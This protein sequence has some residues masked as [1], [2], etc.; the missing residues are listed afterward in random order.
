MKKKSTD[1]NHNSKPS[2]SDEHS[3]EQAADK[4][5]LEEQHILLDL[6]HIR[7]RQYDHA[8]NRLAVFNK[9]EAA[10]KSEKPLAQITVL[11]PDGITSMAVTNAQELKD[12]L[13]AVYSD[14]HGDFGLDEM[15]QEASARAG[16]KLTD[17]QLQY[18]RKVEEQP[19]I[20]LPAQSM[21]EMHAVLKEK[22][23]YHHFGDVLQEEEDKHYN[24]FIREPAEETEQY[25]D[26]GGEKEFDESAEQNPDEGRNLE[27]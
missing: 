10:T 15:P 2:R 17:N 4:Q 13:L 26:L 12:A 3:T 19:G 23:R 11:H 22:E 18:A 27:R 21:E 8:Q 24:E 16:D 14:G 9:E 6:Q 5:Q 25:E 1:K 20:I 7:N